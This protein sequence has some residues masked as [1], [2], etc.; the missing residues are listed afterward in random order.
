MTSRKRSVLLA[1]TASIALLVGCAN[2]APDDVSSRR[3]FVFFLMENAELTPAALATIRAAAADAAALRPRL[4]R[5]TGHAGAAGPTA[6]SRAL[7]QERAKAV[8]AALVAEGVP[9]EH[10][11]VAAEGEAQA[12]SGKGLVDRQ[13]EIEFLI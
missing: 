10:L 3:H 7:S 1:L 2:T 8:A 12:I 4:I 9:R 5:V 6:F 13:V 11:H